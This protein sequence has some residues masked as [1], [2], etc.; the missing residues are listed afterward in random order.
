MNKASIPK[1]IS[2]KKIFLYVVLCLFIFPAKIKA[3]SF[4]KTFQKVSPSVVLIFNSEQAG[5]G[6]VVNKDGLILTNFHVVNT[7]LPLKIKATVNSGQ[8]ALFDDFEIVGIHPKY[9][10]ALIR[11]KPGKNKLAPLKPDK[12]KILKTGQNVVIISSI[13]DFRQ[14]KLQRTITAGIV[15]AAE[16]KLKG[17]PYIQTTAAITPNISGGALSDAKGNFLGL[18]TFKL[19]NTEGIGFAIP[20]IDFDLTEFQPLKEKKPNIEEAEKIAQKGYLRYIKAL[21]TLGD[22]GQAYAR[23]AILLYRLALQH[24]P[25]NSMYYHNIGAIYFDKIR[26]NDSAFEYFKKAVLIDKSRVNSW[27]LLGSIAMD[28]KNIKHAKLCWKNGLK[29]GKNKKFIAKCAEC[30]A[31]RCVSEGEFIK[32]AY[33]IKWANSLHIFPETQEERDKIFKKAEKNL[34]SHQRQEL[35]AMK[36]S[37]SYT[38]LHKF[39]ETSDSAQPQSPG[40]LNIIYENTAEK[41]LSNCPA[42]SSGGK[43]IKIKE[44]PKEILPAYFGCYLLFHHPELKKI[45]VFDIASCRFVKDIRTLSKKTCITATGKYL[46]MYFPEFKVFEKWNLTD[47]KKEKAKVLDLPENVK[48]ISSTLETTEEIIVTYT[49]KVRANTICQYCR[50]NI[51]SYILVPLKNKGKSEIVSNKNTSRI[52]IGPNGTFAIAWNQYFQ[53]GKM[54]INNDSFIFS[55]FPK[56]YKCNINI[57]F[58]NNRFLTTSGAICSYTGEQIISYRDSL[59][60]PILGSRNFIQVKVKKHKKVKLFFKE[61]KSFITQKTF[62]LPL[63]TT[64]K[65]RFGDEPYPASDQIVWANKYLK[66]L[67]VFWAKEKKILI[68]P[69]ELSNEK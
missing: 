60:Y 68:Y 57:D 67:V 20:F 13:A 46:L 9:D 24:S 29:F 65:W 6:V 44:T 34:N 14:K 31:E 51:N 16:R 45:K 37:F 62:E 7:P 54:E 47:F 55:R 1:M 42:I 38:H 56:F 18:A 30:L 2:P 22:Q 27:F 48:S 17:M 12:E 15:S 66:R 35:F 41:L 25:L 11:I 39:A 33:L 49:R 23:E 32:A 4:S 5:S 21:E 58:E 52:K 40:K 36:D 26:Q 19:E 69:L 43:E 63:K 50:L 59:L 3:V 61:G 8:T 10:L 53:W 28:R 64:S